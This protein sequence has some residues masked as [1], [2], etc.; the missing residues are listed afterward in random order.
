M[1]L[2]VRVNDSPIHTP[3]IFHPRA[4]VPNV[5]STAETLQLEA[6]EMQGWSSLKAVAT[7]VPFV[8]RNHQ[9]PHC[10]GSHS[11]TPAAAPLGPTGQKTQNQATPSPTALA[12]LSPP[13]SWL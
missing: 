10:I 2:S 11:P 7:G 9:T 1:E 12:A 4:L 13:A 5:N 8:A 6:S 3:S